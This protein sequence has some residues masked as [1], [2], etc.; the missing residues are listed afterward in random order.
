MRWQQAQHRQLL[1]LYEYQD[2]FLIPD[3]VS[4][5]LQLPLSLIIPGCLKDN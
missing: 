1:F 4:F 2:L 3:S 5:P